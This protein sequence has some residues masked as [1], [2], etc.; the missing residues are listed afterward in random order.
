M[1]TSSQ[2]LRYKCYVVMNLDIRD[3]RLFPTGII[4]FSLPNEWLDDFENY[5]MLQMLNH[6]QHCELTWQ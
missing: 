5:N 6:H 3:L 4:Y 2:N 1:K